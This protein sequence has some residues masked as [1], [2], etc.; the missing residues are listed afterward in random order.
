MKE[1]DQL[2]ADA[3]STVDQ[4]Y[5]KLPIDGGEP[6]YR[7]RVYCYELYHQMRVR[8]PMHTPF[9]VDGEVDKRAH[10][11]LR[12]RGMEFAVPDFLIHVPG[13]M[14]LNHTVVEVKSERA[15]TAGVEQ[16]LKKLAAFRHI[17]GYQRGIYLFFGSNPPFQLVTDMAMRIEGLPEIEL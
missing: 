6:V 8:W 2:L 11:I 7:E 10:P 13:D 16:D 4:T 5:Y 17:V 14:K 9:V 3:T 15:S 12:R 1:L